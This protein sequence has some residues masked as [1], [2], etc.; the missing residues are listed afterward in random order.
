MATTQLYDVLIS[1]LIARPSL[2]VASVVAQMLSKTENTMQLSEQIANIDRL[3]G[4]L[5]SFRP[6]PAGAVRELKQ[7]Y[8]VRFTYQSNAIEGNTLSQS[9]TELVLSKGITIGGKTLGEHL[10]VVGH[11]E[12]IDYIETLSRAETKIGEWEIRQIHSLVMRKITPAEAGRYRQLD[13]RAAGTGYVYP[14]HYLLPGLMDEF[15]QWMQSAQT[16]AHPVLYASEAH[17]RF[18][19]IH[20]FADGNGRTGRLLMNLLL[21]KSGFPIVSISNES[22]KDYI[23]AL[24]AAQQS[25]GDLALLFS[26]VSEMA[27][28]ALI[29]T[30]SVVASAAESK[31]KGQPFYREVVAFLTDSTFS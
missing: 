28:A 30:L 14:P 23:D 16:Q 4:W 10:E 20:P 21:L 15:V 26:L 9:E 6:L 12:A 3:K 22:R 7:R 31:T 27:I 2:T 1:Q 29:E 5:D 8:D 18:V 13:V 24:S 25:Q 11:K 19:S 17:Y